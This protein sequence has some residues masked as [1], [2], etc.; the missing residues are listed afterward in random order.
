MMSMREGRLRALLSF[1]FCIL[2]SGAGIAGEYPEKIIKLIVPYPAGGSTDIL[3][4]SIQQPMS[5]LL[6]Q[7]VIIENKGGGG[8]IIGTEAAAR[9]SPDGYTIVFGNLG[10]NAI[11][12]SFNSKAGYDPIKD[13]APV[14]VVANMPLYLVAYP[15]FQPNNIAELLVLARAKPGEIGFA[16]VG[17]GS[18]SHVTGELFNTMSGVKLLHVP[19]K[20]G[21]PA[22]IDV[23]AGHVPLM[24]ATALEATEHIKQ[25]KLKVLGGTPKGRSPILP[26]VPAISETVPGFDVTVWFGVLAPANTPTAVVA[27]LN[28]VVRRAV[29]L[30]EVQQKLKSVGVDPTTTTPEEFAHTIA[31]DV[32][33]WARVVKTAGVTAE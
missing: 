23:L 12:A 24:F 30:P 25:G 22:M 20:G 18:A 16:S 5:A 19:Y 21:G 8:G 6:G 26:E 11:T 28:S 33:K 29:A 4:R 7:A 1:A 9:S 31:S 13:F 10:P 32:E 27:Q 2:L 17:T 3:A 14:S 15:S